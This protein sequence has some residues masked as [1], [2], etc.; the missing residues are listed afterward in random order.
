MTTH[1]EPTESTSSDNGQPLVK[2]GFGP[3]ESFH[4]LVRYAGWLA[5]QIPEE[6]RKRTRAQMVAYL[7]EVA[8]R[9][10]SRPPEDRER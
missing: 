5:S 6:E 1:T 10:P 4:D 7:D 9:E 2:D 8:A 3:I